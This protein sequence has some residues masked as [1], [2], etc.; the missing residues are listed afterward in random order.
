MKATPGTLVPVISVGGRALFAVQVGV[1]RH[2]S[3]SFQFVHQ[4]VGTRPIP[5][6]SHHSAASG[7]DRPAGGACSSATEALNSSRFIFSQLVLAGY[8]IVPKQVESNAPWRCLQNIWQNLLAWIL[9]RP[10][11]SPALEQARLADFWRDLPPWNCWRR[12]ARLHNL[13]HS[14]CCDRFRD[15]R[16]SSLPPL[17]ERSTIS[18]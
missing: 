10:S 6:A 9:R 17:R 5:L 4:G 16:A 11:L 3:L 12:A 14:S 15:P 8:S 1:H 13:W 7:M 18:G 2:A